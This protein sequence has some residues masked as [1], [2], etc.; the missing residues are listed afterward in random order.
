MNKINHSNFI[1]LILALCFI[2]IFP[3]QVNAKNEDLEENDI[4]LMSSIIYAEAGNQCYAG[5]LAVGIII[6]N[7]VDSKDFPNTINKVIYQKN[8]FGPVS[9][10]SLKKALKLYDRNKLPQKTIKASKEA[11]NNVKE[12]EYKN[13]NINL[14]NFY[15]FNSYVNDAKV[16][17]QDHQFK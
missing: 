8:Q 11:L 13:K 10:G 15:Y 1:M 17:I 9:N 4:R 16:T 3:I 6:M 7:R 5:Q 14:E 2:F 12:V